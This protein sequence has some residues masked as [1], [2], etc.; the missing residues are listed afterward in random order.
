MSAWVRRAEILGPRRIEKQ[1][2]EAKVR[3]ALQKKTVPADNLA[4][5]DLT[6]FWK[7]SHYSQELY[8]G[9][10]IT[11]DQ[12][13]EAEKQLGFTLPE[14]Y[15]TLLKQHNGG[16]LIKNTFDNPLKS[17]WAEP[18]FDVFAIYGIDPEKE[19]SL[20]GKM[21]NQFWLEQWDYPEIGVVFAET[22]NE[23]QDIFMLDYSEC[24]PEGEPFVVH[25]DQEKHFEISFVA[26]NFAEFI[27]G[28]YQG[29]ED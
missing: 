14:A 11:D 5:F 2:F 25:V 7:D 17:E 6:D 24:G 20:L 23:G 12:I 27:K 18:T 1:A 21:G 9:E 3:E 4:D 22:P 26:K 13:K 19:H 8:I 28:L 10:T 16:R 15:K 29:E